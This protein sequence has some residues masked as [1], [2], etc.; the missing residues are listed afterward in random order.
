M[1]VVPKSQVNATRLNGVDLTER[2][3]LSN[4]DEIDLATRV[5]FRV[6]LAAE[7]PAADATIARTYGATSIA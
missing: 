4:G 7:E 1:F 2:A 6:Q 3:E 5:A